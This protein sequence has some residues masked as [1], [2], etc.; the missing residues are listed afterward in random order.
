[1][2]MAHAMLYLVVIALLD[3]VLGEQ[4]G[5]GLPSGGNNGQAA[6]STGASQEQLLAALLLQGSS[7]MFPKVTPNI[8]NFPASGFAS[9]APVPLLQSLAIPPVAPQLASVT[10]PESVGSTTS[11]SALLPA[12]PLALFRQ[13]YQQNLLLQQQLR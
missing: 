7:T 1:M 6:P 4:C 3:V 8:P 13:T 10:G 2:A 9:V 12:N 11:A 5:Q